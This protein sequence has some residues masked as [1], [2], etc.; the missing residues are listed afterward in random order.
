MPTVPLAVVELVMT[1]GRGLIVKVSVAVPVPP[2]FV[3]RSVTL[4]APAA[5]GVPVIKPVVVLTESPAG[6]PVALKPVG[7]F[8]A[9]I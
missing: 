2:L 1:G 4:D 5:V 3:A 9:V 7:L 8:V 6:N